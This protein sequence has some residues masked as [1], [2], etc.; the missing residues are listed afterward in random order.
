LKAD[1][2]WSFHSYI[3][4]FSYND[5]DTFYSFIENPNNLT[6]QLAYNAS[7]WRHN[8]DL[9]QTFYGNKFDF[10][11]EVVYNSDPYGDKSFDNTELV[12]NAYLYD[13]TNQ[14]W[15]EVQFSTVDR[16]YAYN[17]NQMTGIKTLSVTALNPYARVQYGV[18]NATIDKDRNVWRISRIRDL[19]VN[20]LTSNES[21][22]SKDWTI[23]TYSGAFD[24][25]FGYVDKIVNPDYINTSKNVYEMQRLVDKYMS[26]RY[27]Y[28]PA[29]N[30]KLTI[31]LFNT[32]K[33]NRV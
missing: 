28:R 9:Y 8:A 16:F 12:S 17:N 21:M 25:G 15:K 2:W 1:A 32:L 19:S 18:N 5:D 6:G 10:I 30:Y 22:F 7:V 29:E 23:P 4:N 11:L 33:R 31:N 27:F 13:N 3:P 14:F 20:R 26:V 24:R